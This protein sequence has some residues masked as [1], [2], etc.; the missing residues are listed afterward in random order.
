[1]S[2]PSRD[3]QGRN[4]RQPPRAPRRPRRRRTAQPPRDDDET[5][6]DES[7]ESYEDD[8]TKDGDEDIEAGLSFDA[9]LEK[10]DI[11]SRRTNPDQKG[12]DKGPQPLLVTPSLL[13]F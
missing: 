10:V 3:E 4:P 13:L 2:T 8:E 7:K 9:K 5:K 11:E 1:M 6:D 12:N